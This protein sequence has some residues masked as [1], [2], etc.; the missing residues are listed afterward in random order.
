MSQMMGLADK[1]IEIT[2]INIFI[3]FK[4]LEET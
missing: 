4:N 2:I 3:I 1:N